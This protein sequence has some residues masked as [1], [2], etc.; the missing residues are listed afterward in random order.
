MA[1][2]SVFMS[3]SLLQNHLM[4]N[5]SIAMAFH[6]KIHVNYQPGSRGVGN[7]RTK[8][9]LSEQKPFILGVAVPTGKLRIFLRVFM[10]HPRGFYGVS[11]ATVFFT[12]F[13]RPKTRFL[14]FQPK[15]TK[16]HLNCFIST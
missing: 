12:G 14:H 8:T 13:L 2:S 4:H 7:S 6:G 9:R 1:H 16:T 15:M 10:G 11:T 5:S 3:K